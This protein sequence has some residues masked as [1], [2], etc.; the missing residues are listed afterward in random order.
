MCTSVNV[1]HKSTAFG[2]GMSSNIDEENM[3][4]VK[5]YRLGNQDKEYELTDKFVG[6]KPE[7]YS[8]WREF[9]RNAIALN[10]ESLPATITLVSP[11][12]TEKVTLS[13]INP[14]AKAAFPSE[15]FADSRADDWRSFLK[16]S[17][18]GAPD[19]QFIIP[20]YPMT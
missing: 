6:W 20:L 19:E 3:S 18:V 5:K 16:V 1:H 7:G 4:E 8:G 10:P 2:C 17:L 9:H 11:D 12:G 15:I 14:M 13:V